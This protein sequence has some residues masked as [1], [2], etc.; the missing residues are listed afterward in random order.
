MQ[1]PFVFLMNIFRKYPLEMTIC[2]IIVITTAGVYYPV[3]WHEFV[4]Y[5]D[6]LYIINN[7]HIQNGLTW[8]AICW[9]FTTTRGGS[10]HPLTWISHMI[11]ISWYGMDAGGHHWTNVQ[12]HLISALLLFLFLRC[13]TQ[14]IYVSA[15]IT[16]CFALHPLHVESVVW[17]AERKDVLSVCLAHL[18]LLLYVWYI[19]A[20]DIKRKIWVWLCF[21]LSL[22]SKPMMITLPVLLLVLDFWPLKRFHSRSFYQLIKEKEFML[23]LALVVAGLTLLSQDREGYIILDVPFHYRLLNASISYCVY[24]WKMFV[25]ANLTIFYPHPGTDISVFQGLLA[26]IVLILFSLWM[27][28]FRDRLPYVFTGTIWYLLTL[29]PVIGI[30]KLGDQQLAERYTYFPM[31]GMVIVLFF[32]I[33]AGYNQAVLKYFSNNNNRLWYHQ[34]GILFVGMLTLCLSI[35]SWHQIKIWKN[36]T[37]LF[38]N[39]LELTPNSCKAKLGRGVAY[40]KQQQIPEAIACYKETIRRCPL[41]L[42]AHI[43]LGN[44]LAQHKH[45]YRKALNHYKFALNELPDDPVVINNIGNIEMLCNH[46]QNALEWYIRALNADDSYIHTFYNLARLINHMHTQSRLF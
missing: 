45:E 8:D 44:I 37:T 11:D 20:P 16:V 27:T 41:M 13:A 10:W 6:Q 28:H 31:T 2:A 46:P 4:Y 22:M 14:R 24:I 15:A 18:T 42:N 5:D 19:E 29:I 33:A 32:S 25:P 43:N 36:D 7:P 23:L 34:T 35:I 38:S 12:I 3:R 30:V 9:A 21:C 17:V 39:A 26:W 40:Q 1:K